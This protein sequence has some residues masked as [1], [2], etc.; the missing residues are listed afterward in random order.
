M[1]GT[2]AMTGQRGRSHVARDLAVVAAVALG[3][4]LLYLIEIRAS[5]WFDFLHLDP[6]YYYDWGLRIAGGDWLGKEVFEQSPLYPYLLGIYFIL[7]GHDLLLLRLI[8]FALGAGTAVLTCLLG[9][10]LFGRT[11]GLVAGLGAALYAP[12]LFYEGQVMKEFLTPLFS[13]A[14]LLLIYRGRESAKGSFPSLALAGLCIGLGTLVRD[15]FLILLPLL[16]LYLLLS[17]GITI[18]GARLRLLHAATLVAGALI[19]LLPVAWRNHH[20]ASE[21][22]LTTSGGGEVFYIGNGPFANGAYL[23]PPWVRSNPRYEHEDFRRRAKEITGRELSRG[24]ASRFWYREGWKAIADDPVRWVRLLFRKA[25]LFL[26]DH[27]LPDNYSFYSFRRFS[28]TL[29]LLPTFA[30]VFSLAVPGAIVSSKRWRELLPLILAGAGYM[31]SVM[32]FFN[33]ARFRLPFIPI[34]LVFAGAGAVEIARALSV[35]RSRILRP[36][37]AAGRAIGLVAVAVA[38]FI[39]VHV[40]LSSNAEEP[41]QDRLHLGA[42]YKIAGKYPEAEEVLRATVRDA[43]ALL[44]KHGWSPG[45]GPVPGGITFQLALHAAHRDLAGVL[46]AE[47]HPEQAIAELQAAIPLD[48]NDAELFQT[49]GGAYRETGD[50]KAAR[51]AYERGLAIRPDSFTIRFDLAT[52]IYESG[53]AE[54]S[55]RE[56]VIARE[57]NPGLADLDLAD[58]HYGMGTTLNAIPGR[59]REAREHLKEGLRLNPDHPQA[60]EVRSILRAS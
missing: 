13:V 45:A 19:A 46:L 27:E 33:F 56:L 35:L 17:P 25:L 34:L 23:P 29:T 24:E 7:F 55:L 59:A 28:S 2:G 10:K 37:R 54:G 12:F 20:V 21:W 11:A 30:F 3:V 22:V 43:E 48:P 53:D 8:Q 1:T 44:V 40:D 36:D 58:W 4:R 51:Q 60:A 6:R 39:S 9:R 50:T 32:L 31:G 41:F 52:A 15:N 38:L 57:R 5:P 16:A 18:P 26:N 42:A 14:A 49:L 47:K